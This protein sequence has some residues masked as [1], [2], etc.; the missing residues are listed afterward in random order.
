M[1]SYYLLEGHVQKGSRIVNPGQADALRLI[2]E[3]G[4]AAFY[5]GPIA[6]GIVGSVAGDGGVVTRADLAGY[7]AR[8]VRPLEFGFLGGTVL[9]MP[10]PS[11]GGIA[12]AQILGILEATGG[13]DSASPTIAYD[14]ALVEAMK[15]AFADRA[16]WLGDPEFVDVPSETLISSEYIKARAATID[17]GHTKPSASYGTLPQEASVE[18]ITDHGTSHFCVVDGDGNAVACTETINLEFGSLL[19]VDR[20]GVL[21]QQRGWMI[22]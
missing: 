15:H 5:Q 17:P 12:L 14:H 16:R 10:P 4:A 13:A 11:S 22:S 19:A 3:Y 21:P 8:I 6:E 1:W 18:A 7:T 20:F 9:T 2:A